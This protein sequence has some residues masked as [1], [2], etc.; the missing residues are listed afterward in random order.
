MSLFI[1]TIG[2]I[3]L[4]T[5]FL[6]GTMTKLLPF[7]LA[8][9]TMTFLSACGP[10]LEVIE[11]YENGAKKTSAQYLGD[12][13]KG[14]RKKAFIYHYSE[15]G[16]LIKRENLVKGVTEYYPD[17]HR[18]LSSVKGLEDYFV[19]EWSVSLSLNS[20]TSDSSVSPEKVQI[21]IQR[22]YEKS[23]E[24][25][26]LLKITPINLDSQDPVIASPGKVLRLSTTHLEGMY[27]CNEYRSENT[28]ANHLSKPVD[29][30]AFSNNDFC[31]IS[32]HNSFTNQ[33]IEYHRLA[34]RHL[35][36]Q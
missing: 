3:I 18:A 1:N 27:P 14:R 6:F 32:E 36:I 33:G 16:E 19:G 2:I 23:Y 17:L 20:S 21:S 7:I 29:E 35:N 12:G 28:S 9:M 4:F 5:N 25:F 22:P 34:N 24:G 15:K 8:A 10:N 30:A 31:F 26:L 13:V 11:S